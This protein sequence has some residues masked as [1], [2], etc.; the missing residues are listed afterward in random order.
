MTAYIAAMLLVWVCASVALVI[1]TLL[2]AARAYLGRDRRMARSWLGMSLPLIVL[3]L[4]TVWL[5][6]HQPGHVWAAPTPDLR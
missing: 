4:G 1:G 6:L 3:C 2:R 5:L